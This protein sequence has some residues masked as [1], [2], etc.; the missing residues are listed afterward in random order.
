MIGHVWGPNY[1]SN[2]EPSNQISGMVVSRLF[3]RRSPL[4]RPAICLLFIALPVVLIWYADTMMRPAVYDIARIKA[5]QIATEAIN[6]SVQKK[7]GDSNLQYSDFI[8][9]HKDSQGRIVLMQANTIKMNQLAADVTLAVQGALKRLEDERF[10]IPLGQA[11]GSFFLADRG[12]RIKVSI[13]P[14]GI[15]RVDVKD[16]FENAGIN[17]TRH[18]IYLQ[19]ETEVRIVVPFISGETKVATHVPVAESIIVGDVPTT[20]VTLPGGLFGEG[21]IK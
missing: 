12:P 14:A 1:T 7:V 17:Q 2:P 6:M 8:L 15:V 18:K 19:F 13:M 20:F 11:T 5:I 4:K 10:Y 16:K 21:I 3:K 9:I